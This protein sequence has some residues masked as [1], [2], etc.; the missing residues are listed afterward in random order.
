M[1]LMDFVHQKKLRWVDLFYRLDTDKSLAISE[2]EFR[3]GLKV[4]IFIL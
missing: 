1:Q 2:D 3:T 4:I